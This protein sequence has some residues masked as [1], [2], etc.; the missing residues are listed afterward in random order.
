MRTPKND[1]DLITGLLFCEGI[2]QKIS[3]IEKIECLGEKV[4]KFDL[5]N[6]IRITLGN[7]EN[8]DTKKP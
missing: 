1:E 8:L 4:G 3:D 7:S 5:Q 6:K 2:V